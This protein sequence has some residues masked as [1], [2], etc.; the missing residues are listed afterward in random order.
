LPAKQCS[1][2]AVTD[3]SVYTGKLGSKRDESAINR[4]PLEKSSDLPNSQNLCLEEEGFPLEAKLAAL[5]I[6]MSEL[7]MDHQ[8]I[9][10]NV[11]EVINNLQILNAYL[12]STRGKIMKILKSNYILRNAWLN[13]E[14]MYH[15]IAQKHTDVT[16]RIENLNSENRKLLD[17][18]KLKTVKIF[19]GNK[20]LQFQ[21]K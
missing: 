10:T 20:C 12:V 21:Q 14:K 11:S 17:T 15:D 5:K 13:A 1:S 2:Y 6:S 3:I 19:K 18:E 8:D 16:Y 7:Q 9:D 4:N